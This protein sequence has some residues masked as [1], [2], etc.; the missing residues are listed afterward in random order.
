M[1]DYGLG[2]SARNKSDSRVA[3]ELN[4]PLQMTR[5]HKIC[6]LKIPVQLGCNSTEEISLIHQLFTAHATLENSITSLG[7]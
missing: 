6:I 7:N 3:A 2:G 5:A 1:H 4:T